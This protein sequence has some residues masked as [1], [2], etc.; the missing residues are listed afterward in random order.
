MI[1]YFILIGFFLILIS[2]GNCEVKKVKL[3]YDIYWG[4]FKVGESQI[5]I[6]PDKYIAIVYSLG[7][8]KSIFPF[9]AKWETW[10][11]NEGYPEMS[12]IY[13]EEKNKKR[14]RILYFKKESNKIV[15]QKLL[16]DIKAPE[17][18]FVKFPIYD[19]LS[20][21]ITSFFIDYFSYPKKELPI[22]VKKSREYVKLNFDKKLECNFLKDKK[23]CLKINVYLPEKSELLKRSSEVEI[24][25]L[26]KERY[27]LELKGKLP[28]FGS[29]TG[30]LNRVEY[31]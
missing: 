15:L 6:L 17:E 14:K 8:V 22:Y 25:L 1:R 24:F 16:P 29:L 9:Y 11:D 7:I 10:V 31:L 19:E 13:S 23:M 26:E 28:I 18:I 27:P 12:I 5:Q 3:F 21:F 4:P 20:S 2:Q 30:K